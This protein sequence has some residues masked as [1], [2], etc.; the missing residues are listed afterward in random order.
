MHFELELKYNLWFYIV[1][2]R[3][4]ILT[5]VDRPRRSVADTTSVS[6]FFYLLF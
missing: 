1:S 2:S 3:P 4:L 6:L 5:A